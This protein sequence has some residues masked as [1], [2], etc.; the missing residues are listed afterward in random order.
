MNL[1]MDPLGD[2]LT[3][4]PI[5]NGWEFTMEPYPSGQFWLIHN[6]DRQ[7]GN[8]SAWPWT[9]TQSDGPEPLL[10]LAMLAGKTVIVK[11]LDKNDCTEHYQIIMW[12]DKSKMKGLSISC[13]IVIE[14]CSTVKYGQLLVS[15]LHYRL[16]WRA[17]WT[18]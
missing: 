1:Q 7:F 15:I 2:L 17:H 4:H 3:P 11:R 6:P 5:Q 10:T 14:T 13:N 8:G 9:W 16:T 12:V 18:W